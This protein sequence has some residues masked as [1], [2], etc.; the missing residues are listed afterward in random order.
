VCKSRA[1]NLI[2]IS[3]LILS[4]DVYPG[5]DTHESCD[6]TPGNRDAAAA[7]IRGLISTSRTHRKHASDRYKYSCPRFCGRARAAGEPQRF[8][9]FLLPPRGTREETRYSAESK[10]VI[11]PSKGLLRQR[12]TRSRS[13]WRERADYRDRL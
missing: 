5:R 10:H 2:L 12:S 4:P 6:N 13:S 9:T 3:R 1:L 7:A 8:F 11:L